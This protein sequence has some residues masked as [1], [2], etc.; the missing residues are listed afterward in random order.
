MV[1][2]QGSDER[3]LNALGRAN[4][5][6]SARAKLKRELT[7]G[8]VAIEEVIAQPPGFAERAKVADL[9]LAVPG[10]GP[11]RTT[12]LLV[13]SQIPY[14]KTLTSLS[15]RQRTVLISLLRS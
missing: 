4:A 14:G 7:S 2:D 15:E 6:R 9:L 10:L 8:N 13:R 11:A 12:G 5:V 1:P 3:R